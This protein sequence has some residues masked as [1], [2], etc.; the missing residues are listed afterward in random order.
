MENVEM[1]VLSPEEKDGKTHERWKHGNIMG[2][3]SQS[4]IQ[5]NRKRNAWIQKLSENIIEYCNVWKEHKFSRCISF[6]TILIVIIKNAYPMTTD[7]IVLWEISLPKG[8]YFNTKGLD[9]A[10]HLSNAPSKLG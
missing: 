10:K 7:F 3:D 2:G 5:N 8:D 6:N 1:R 9:S 4:E